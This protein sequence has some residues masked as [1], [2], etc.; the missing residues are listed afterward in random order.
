MIIKGRKL[1]MVVCERSVLIQV[2]DRFDC[3]K[4]GL[5]YLEKYNFHINFIFRDYNRQ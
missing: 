5:P 1:E 3:S 2:M 4:M